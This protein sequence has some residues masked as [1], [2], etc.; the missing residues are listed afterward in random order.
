MTC[1]VEHGEI[2]IGTGIATKIPISISSKQRNVLFSGRTGSGKSFALKLILKR[3][4]HANPSAAIFVIDPI[5]NGYGDIAKDCG[6]T[7]VSIKDGVPES[8][9]RFLFTDLRPT[10]DK[11]GDTKKLLADIFDRVQYRVRSLPVDQPKLVIFDELWSVANTEKGKETL[12]KMPSICR[13]RNTL[14]LASI[15]H[16]DQMDMEYI[17]MFVTQIHMAP[18]G[19]VA[20]NFG[21][22]NKERIKELKTG[23]GLIS[24]DDQRIYVHFE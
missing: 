16:S 12:N 18:V 14:F 5:V 4:A 13:N 6:L 10:L 1:G 21:I 2:S 8:G 24:N 7:T 3:F 9:D 11:T 15:Q 17:K 23:C 20:P 19:D 22:E